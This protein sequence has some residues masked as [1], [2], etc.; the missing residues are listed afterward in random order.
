MKNGAVIATLLVSDALKLD[1]VLPTMYAII[2]CRP[3]VWQC[4]AYSLFIGWFSI[5]TIGVANEF[6]RDLL[7]GYSK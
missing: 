7:R 1:K 5:T 3:F 4:F 6:S 2:E